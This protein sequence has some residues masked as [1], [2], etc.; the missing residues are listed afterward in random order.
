MVGIVEVIPGLPRVWKAF[1]HIV[2]TL[3]A[4]RPALAVL[5]DFPEFNLR[6]ARKLNQAG[7]EVV[8]FIAPQVWAWRSGRLASLRQYVDR[9]L[10]IFPFEEEYFRKAGVRA[11]FV[12]HPLVG[13]VGPSMSESQWR[14]FLRLPQKLPLV[15]LLPGSRQ[16][17]ISLNLPPMLAAARKI[18]ENGDYAFVAAAASPQADELIR[19]QLGDSGQRFVVVENHTYDAVAH[20]SATIVA[21]GTAT[22]E[23]ALLGTP[24]VVVYR[25]TGATWHLGRRLVR[26]PFY[27]MVNLVAGRQI[28]PEFIQ[29]GFQPDTVAEATLKLLRNPAANEETRA[30]L[31]EVTERLR[32]PRDTN[33]AADAIARSVSVMESILRTR[34][35][36]EVNPEPAAPVRR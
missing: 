26:T 5:I 6:L 2:E 30:R 24:M 23:T 3:K 35:S 19:S 36:E 14:S 28:V 8:Y 4:R 16:R 27:S 12:G 29:D 25:V 1:R 15:A 7:I 13:R 18:A 17:E 31:S 9:L 21:S 32:A 20:A 34:F 22:I 11:E 10:C 33:G